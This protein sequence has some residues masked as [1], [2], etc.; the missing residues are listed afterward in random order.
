M[1]E[2]TGFSWQKFFSGLFNPLNLAKAAV[3]G[4][5]LTLI[6]L[7]VFC[8]VFT[9][10]WLKKKLNKPKNPPQPITITTESGPVHNSQDE[11]RKKFGLINLW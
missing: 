5:H 2:T 8:V 10:L 6:L 4:A 3:F 7:F 11:I 1:T 9:G